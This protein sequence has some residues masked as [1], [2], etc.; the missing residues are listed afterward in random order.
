MYLLSLNGLYLLQFYW[1]LY[2]NCYY[3]P[4]MLLIFVSTFVY[5]FVLIY[6]CFYYLSFLTALKYNSFTFPQISSS[7]LYSSYYYSPLCYSSS[8]IPFF[9]SNSSNCILN[10]FFIISNWFFCSFASCFLW[11]QLGLNQYHF[12]GFF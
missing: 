4:K 2:F 7:S 12:I 11:L 9:S 6:F 10:N 5:F 8:K 1:F 3:F